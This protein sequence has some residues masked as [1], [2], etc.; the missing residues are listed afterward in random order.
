MFHSRPMEWSEEHNVLFVREMIARNGFGTK[1]GSPARRL[2]WEAIVDS[3]NEIHSPKFQLKDKKKL[4]E[5]RGTFSEK[6]GSA[7][8]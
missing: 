8:K 4:Y 7:K 6:K 1:K 2:A 3:V 5:S